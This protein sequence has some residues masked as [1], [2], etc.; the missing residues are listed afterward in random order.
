MVIAFGSAVPAGRAFA[1]LCPMADAPFVVVV[2]DDD[3]QRR[4]LATALSASGYRV[5]AC[6]SYEEALAALDV[7]APD[8]LIAD[9]SLGSHN[10]LQ[11]ADTVARRYPQATRIVLTAFDDIAV[12][13]E[14]MR[15]GTR[16]LLKPFKNAELEGL[17]DAT[18]RAPAPHRGHST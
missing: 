11:L 1:R 14:A 17:L 6:R 7:E 13:R 18:V 2:E 10:G 16:V 4:A 15:N 5:T 9:V 8:V 3:N 12:R